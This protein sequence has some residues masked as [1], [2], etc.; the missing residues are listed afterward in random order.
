MAHFHT[1]VFL[2]KVLSEINQGNLS[3]S[4]I[5]CRIFVSQVQKSE[6]VEPHVLK[7]AV[8]MWNQQQNLPVLHL[9]FPVLELFMHLFPGYNKLHKNSSGMILCL[10][11]AIFLLIHYFPTI[12]HQTALNIKP[13]FFPVCIG[14]R[15][16]CSCYLYWLY[17]L[18]LVL[19]L[20]MGD[21]RHECQSGAWLGCLYC[22]LLL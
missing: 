14:W 13:Q 19:L 15:Y 21:A 4:L 10:F 9:H 8:V 18:H 12:Q 16:V 5:Q 22:G 17:L 7:N 6:N 20:Y 1:S 11:P 3:A 2:D